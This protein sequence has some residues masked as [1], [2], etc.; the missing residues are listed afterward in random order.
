MGALNASR[1]PGGAAGRAAPAGPGNPEVLAAPSEAAART[2][3]GTSIR[4]PGEYTL[5]GFSTRPGSPPGAADGA[6]RRR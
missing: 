5:V 2:S 3:R 6:A 4:P 1:A